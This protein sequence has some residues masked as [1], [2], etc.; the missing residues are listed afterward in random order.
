MLTPPRQSPF[1]FTALPPLT[2]YVHL[3]WCV[4]KCPYCDF[5]SHALRETLPERRYV[6]A[7]L[8]NLD[9]EL[10][11]IGERRVQAIFI[12]GGTPS[13]FSGEAIA[14]LLAGIG[15]RL[16]L[17]PDPEITLEANPSTVEQRKFSHFRAA[18]VNRLSIGA[19]SFNDDCLRRLGRIH[20]AREVI[21][22]VEAAHAA[23][24]DNLNIDLMF[25]LPGQDI[26]GCLQDLRTA[27]ALAPAHISFYQLTIEPHTLFHSQPP[28]LPDEDSICEMQTLGQRL[29]ADHGYNQYEVSAYARAR[30]HCM[31]NLNYWQFGDY[32]GIG[33]G[34]H[35]KLSCAV[36]Q[37]I[38]RYW[39]HR[40][41][42]QYME[43]A[44]RGQA[45]AGERMLNADDA[46]FE[47]ML[48]AL[49][50]T[51][52]FELR[53]FTERT[54]LSAQALTPKLAALVGRGLL[55]RSQDECIGATALGRRFLNDLIEHFLPDPNR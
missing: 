32:L 16:A 22:A 17:Q 41:P 42:R 34:A 40:Q 43:R 27:V 36:T 20:G 38:W 44:Q 13:L 14:R 30:Q 29:L 28:I 7:L 39:N 1:N 55:W 15:T 45:L 25:G 4:R 54:S 49:R 24:F 6:D 37:S 9:W 10:P 51:Q 33:A 35:G 18:G 31:H 5:N 3:P 47:F 46:R 19:Q 50:L 26:D 52:G 2:L 12:G 11:R 53:L 48:N 23:G 21:R 8:S